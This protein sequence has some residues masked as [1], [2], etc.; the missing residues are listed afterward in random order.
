MNGQ[1]CLLLS[2]REKNSSGKRDRSRRLLGGCP[3]GSGAGR[4]PPRRPRRQRPSRPPRLSLLR[5]GEMWA[6]PRVGESGGQAPAGA[7]APGWGNGLPPTEVR[8]PPLPRVCVCLRGI[9]LGWLRAASQEA[10]I[11]V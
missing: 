1:Y 11:R 10:L 6:R 8:L 7:A 9:S 4:S 2:G 5:V 3:A